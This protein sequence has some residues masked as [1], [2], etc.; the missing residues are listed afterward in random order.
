MKN[1][2]I[3]DRSKYHGHAFG[4]KLIKMNASQIL[5]IKINPKWNINKQTS[6]QKKEKMKVKTD[7]DFWNNNNFLMGKGVCMT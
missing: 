3:N 2:S 1:N 4:G 5:Y 7:F 6:M